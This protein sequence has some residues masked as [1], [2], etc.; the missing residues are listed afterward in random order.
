MKICKMQFIRQ[1]LDIGFR[2]NAHAMWKFLDLRQT[3]TISIQEL[4]PSAAKLLS[5]FKLLLLNACGT[6][7]P[8][9]FCGFTSGCKLNKEEFSYALTALG[10][11]G[12]TSR[13]FDLL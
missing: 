12:C 10:F 5:G 3:G 1:L 13:L 8:R 7:S 11:R 4:D 2:E 9:D 6:V